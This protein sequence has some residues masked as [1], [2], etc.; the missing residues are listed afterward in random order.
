VSFDDASSEAWESLVPA[1][2][3]LVAEVSRLRLADAR[4]A[5][6]Q[7]GTQLSDE[8][9]RDV[10]NE[11]HSFRVQLRELIYRLR[12]LGADTETLHEYSAQKTRER[13]ADIVHDLAAASP[14]DGERCVLCERVLGLGPIVQHDAACPWRRAVEA[15]R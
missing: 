13:Y 4:A 11:L 14:I 5:H 6:E 10:V 8:R 7:V 1:L 15:S 12:K 2:F 9:Q 3:E